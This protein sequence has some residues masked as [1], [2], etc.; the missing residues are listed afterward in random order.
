M[1][2]INQQ[3]HV[4]A[5]Y[6]LNCLGSLRSFPKQIDLNNQKYIFSDGLQ[7]LVKIGE[8]IIRIFE[9]SDG[10]KTYRLRLENNQWTLVGT[11]QD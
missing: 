5:F 10:N 2:Y 6:F 11:K 3:V 8:R 7:Y 1:S 9:M 4:D